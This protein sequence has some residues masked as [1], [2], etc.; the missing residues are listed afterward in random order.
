MLIDFTLKNFLSFRDEVSF[1]MLAAK[2]VKEHDLNASKESCN[3][4]EVPG[5]DSKSLKV[6]AVYGANSSGKSNLLVAMSFFKKMIL[7]SFKNDN[8]LQNANKLTFQFSV[9]TQNEPSSFE[10]IFLVDET[11]YRYG[12]E[13][14]G[15]SVV[16]EWLFV[17]P[18]DSIRESYCFKREEKD[19]T[20]NV[21]TY[22]G[23]SGIPS[24]TRHN[25]LFL[26]TCSQFNVEV[27]MTI[28]DWFRK[29]FNILSGID[30]DTIH[31]TAN[32]YLHNA[33]MHK[34]IIDFVRLIDL[35]IND[36]AIKESS[37]DKVSEPIQRFVNTLTS[38]Q[39]IIQPEITNVR[40]LEIMSEH[41]RYDRDEVKDKLYVP[42]GI[43]SLGTKKIFALLGPWFDTIIHGGT[44]LID[45]FGASL[46]THLSIELIK[47]FQ[48]SLNTGAQ[49]IITTHDTNLLR[50]EL[51]RRDQIWF[52]EKD[53]Y[54]SSD[55][56][57]LVEYK[58]DQASSVR[59]DA[60]YSKNYLLGK[61]GA[62]PYFGNIPQ[63]IADF[64]D[65]SK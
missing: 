16:S 17:K 41:I 27:A 34:R 36:I 28:K 39:S 62:I 51:L 11:R 63:F 57:S 19:I 13:I 45:E 23:A 1:S 3:V 8:I 38:E 32:Q 5:I 48:S 53:K 61:Y 24:K 4:I 60:S 9:E 46:H 44:L 10:M 15:E 47:M 43:E 64:A 40:K 42:F 12:F 26:S 25:S 20:V 56:Y 54:G 52:T 35:G 65:E 37:I 14:K 30:D 49:L 21:K 2:S 31:Y 7:E 58:I 59:N 50:G 29:K 6:A 33:E 18:T 22:K 55:L